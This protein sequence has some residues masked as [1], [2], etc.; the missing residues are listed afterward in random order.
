MIGDIFTNNLNIVMKHVGNL[1]M[2]ISNSTLSNI[3]M[4]IFSH[5]KY[6]MDLTTNTCMDEAKRKN[7]LIDQKSLTSSNMLVL[8]EDKL[9]HILKVFVVCQ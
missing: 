9:R 7:F 4:L 3:I 5:K 8:I 1:C 2:T 6:C